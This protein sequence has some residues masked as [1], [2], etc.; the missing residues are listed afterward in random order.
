MPKE[1]L[2]GNLDLLYRPFL[3]RCLSLLA[4]CNDLG[5]RYVLIEGHRSYARSAE[6]YRAYKAGGPRAA[7]AGA[8][9]H[10][11]GLAADFVLDS[12]PAP[13]LQP[14]WRP[15]AFETLVVEAT[16]L[17]LS[18]GAAYKDYPHVEW[19]VFIT[20]EQ[21]APLAAVYKLA[22]GTELDKLR[23]VWAYCDLKSPNLPALESE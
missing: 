1:Q 14:D 15:Q 22:K 19:P 10:N 2:R 5:F 12:S 16:K 23:Q 18:P 13:G 9:G 7:P 21:L 20:G 11:F 6:L 8:S 3:Q 17:G 4:R